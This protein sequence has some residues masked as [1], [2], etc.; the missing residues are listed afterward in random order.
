MLDQQIKVRL[1]VDL[2]QYDRQLVKGAEGI[3]VGSYG[4]WS[5]ASDRFVG[6]RFPDI[7]TFDILWQSLE[8]TDRQFLAERKLRQ[9]AKL[10]ALRT[11]ANVTCC[12]GPRGGF[13]SLSYK[14]LD[15]NGVPC[16]ESTG[17]REECDKLT[18][19]FRKN[20]IAIRNEISK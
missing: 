14:Y 16:H 2:S 10:K 7:G 11:A 13:R 5:R 6:V 8:I 1:L 15:E 19:F 17:D 20:G 18:Q 3:T 4:F 12:M 9:K